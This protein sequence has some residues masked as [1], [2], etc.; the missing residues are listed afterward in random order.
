MSAAEAGT[1]ADGGVR[2]DTAAI[3]VVTGG[4]TV[5]AGV[6]DTVRDIEP[7][8]AMQTSKTCTTVSAT[9]P[10]DHLS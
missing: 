1:V 10:E 5:V 6:Q 8:S 2:A 4:V 3:V 7:G 9:S